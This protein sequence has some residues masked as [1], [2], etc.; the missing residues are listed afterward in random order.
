MRLIDAD[1][2]KSVEKEVVCGK[3]RSPYEKDKTAVL[4]VFEVNEIRNAPTVDAVPISVIES[5]LYEISLNNCGDY[6]STA[7]EE[8]ISRLD[9]LKSYYE[10]IKAEAEKV[11]LRGNENCPG[12]EH[13][14][15]WCPGCQTCLCCDY[16]HKGMEEFP[17]S[18]CSHNGGT[19]N[20]WRHTIPIGA[21]IIEREY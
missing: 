20:I 7:C 1:A 5:W 14:N 17:C 21:E 9:G 10:D 11:V 12:C 3:V 15:K 18:I 19:E 2:L 16:D 8:I 13:E 6:L 4:R